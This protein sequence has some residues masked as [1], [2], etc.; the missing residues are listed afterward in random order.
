MESWTVP[1]GKHCQPCAIVTSMRS[2][3]TTSC[4]LALLF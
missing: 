3:P 4:N 2:I 1:V